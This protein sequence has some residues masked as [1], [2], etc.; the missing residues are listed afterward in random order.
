[1][2]SLNI[3]NTM[4]N[5]TIVILAFLVT[6]FLAGCASVSDKSATNVNGETLLAATSVQA[7]P[8]T[9]QYAKAEQFPT[10]LFLDRCASI[11]EEA[12]NNFLPPAR[13]INIRATSYTPRE[14]A[15]VATFRSIP[16]QRLQT[17]PVV[18]KAVYQEMPETQFYY[19][20]D[21]KQNPEAASRWLVKVANQPQSP[22]LQEAQALNSQ[23]ETLYQQGKYAE[24]INLAQRV[25]AIREQALGPMHPDD[26]VW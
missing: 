26:Y 4:H 16:P 3:I 7:K 6:I 5:H 2:N 13:S 10:N 21:T 19:D 20:I 15:A 14:I 25:L 22:A 8:I 9:V 23:V 12:A 24:A 11:G 18:N 1:M 17:L